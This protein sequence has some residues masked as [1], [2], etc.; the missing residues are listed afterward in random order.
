MPIHRV[1]FATEASTVIE[2]DMPEGATWGE[3]AD[4]ASSALPGGLCKGC[5]GDYSLADTVALLVDDEPDPDIVDPVEKF[6]AALIEHFQ[7]AESQSLGLG[8]HDGTD[9]VSAWCDIIA[10]F[11]PEG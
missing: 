2:V 7:R 5:G 9:L 11:Q 8:P 4:A 10:D 1:Y 6:R 3:I